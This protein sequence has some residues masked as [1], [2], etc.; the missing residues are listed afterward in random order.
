LGSK[1]YDEFEFVLVASNHLGTITPDHSAFSNFLTIDGSVSSFPN[2]RGDAQ[3]VVPAPKS[4]D[5][6]YAH[7]A[8]FVKS[9]SLTEYH[10]FWKRVGKEYSQKI[11]VKKKWLSTSGLGVHWLH[12]RIDS[13]PKYYQFKEY[14]LS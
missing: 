2:L 5:V 7:I 12:V 6:D 10:D 14:K 8:K 13:R 1:T 9:A 11:G 4:D 3:L